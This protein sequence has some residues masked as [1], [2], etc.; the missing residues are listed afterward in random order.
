[1]NASWRCSAAFHRPPLSTGRAFGLTPS[2][3]SSADRAAPGWLATQ[4]NMTARPNS[5][6][7]GGASRGKAPAC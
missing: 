2:C 5:A 6:G 1:M 7:A 4:A 3:A